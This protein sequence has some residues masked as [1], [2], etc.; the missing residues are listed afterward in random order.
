MKTAPK[1]SK[2][3]AVDPVAATEK[4]EPTV[5][6]SVNA[7][8]FNIIMAGLGELPHKHVGTLINDLVAQ[9]QPQVNAAAPPLE[10]ANEE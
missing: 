1:L 8:Q 9:V 7:Q 6:L 5:N 4:S 3:K 10:V 2:V